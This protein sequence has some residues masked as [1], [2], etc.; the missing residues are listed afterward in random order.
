MPSLTRW[1]VS[2]DAD[3]VYRTLTAYGPRSSMR[4]ARELGVAKARVQRALDEL[5]AVGAA[6]PAAPDSGARTWSAAPPDHV[7]S[8]LRHPRRADSGQAERWRRHLRAVAGTDL[9]TVDPEAVQRLTSRAQAQQRIAELMTAERHEHLAIN[10][11]EVISADAAQAALPLDRSVR[12]R[13]IRMR[14]VGRPAADGDLDCSTATELAQLGGDYREAKKVP[15]KLMVF[16]RRA[17]LF[18]ADPVD[19]EAGAVV[20]TDPAAVDHFTQLFYR[21][22]ATAADPRRQGVQPIVLTARE[23]TL[24]ALLTAG[25][26]EA[27]AAAELGVSRRTVVYTLRTLMDRLQVDNRFQLALVLG[28]TRTIPLPD[29]YDT[30][31]YTREY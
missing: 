17:A 16:D 3:L 9:C 5:E 12:A 18:P 22:W 25:H 1:G 19:F 13:G 11:E 31:N 24:V 7:L 2:A 14:V 30:E 6:R 26:S 15:L 4:A 8:V 21:L 23:Q 27:S 28:G 29:P 10:T 20:V